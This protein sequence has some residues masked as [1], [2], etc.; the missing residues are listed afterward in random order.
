MEYPLKVLIPTVPPSLKRLQGYKVLKFLAI[1]RNSFSV[2]FT[3]ALFS[4][5]VTV[6]AFFISSLISCND[7]GSKTLLIR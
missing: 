6:R 2:R 5:L 7:F 3:V 4:L 1:F